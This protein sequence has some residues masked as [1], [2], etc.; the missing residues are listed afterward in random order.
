[1][2]GHEFATGREYREQPTEIERG[3]SLRL[4][5]GLSR[6]TTL[7]SLSL[8][9]YPAGA[10]HNPRRAICPHRVPPL[11]SLSRRALAYAK[12]QMLTLLLSHSG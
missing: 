5:P 9:G 1:M 4:S 2:S 3:L 6:A 11:Y 10:S 12:G 8:P 7:R